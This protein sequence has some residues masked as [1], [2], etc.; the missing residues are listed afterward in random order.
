MSQEFLSDS[1][2]NL[3]QKARQASREAVMQEQFVLTH[4]GETYKLTPQDTFD[5]QTGLITRFKTPDDGPKEAPA[6]AATKG[7]R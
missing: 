4:L 2:R 3:F 6:K 5:I 7:K 1:D